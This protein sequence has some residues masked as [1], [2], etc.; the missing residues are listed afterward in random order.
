MFG[1]NYFGQAYFGESYFGPE[2][3]VIYTGLLDLD[4]FTLNFT[5]IQEFGID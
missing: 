3:L 2:Y 1:N 5:Q 4:L